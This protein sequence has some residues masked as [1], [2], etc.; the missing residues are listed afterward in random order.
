MYTHDLKLV[1]DTVF[2]ESFNHVSKLFSIWKD[3][4]G[5]EEEK[6]KLFDDFFEAKYR[7]ECGY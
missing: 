6:K 5:T 2:V 4:E 3:S 1:G 7:L